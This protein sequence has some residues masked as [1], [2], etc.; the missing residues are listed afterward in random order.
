MSPS[1]PTRV[2]VCEDSKTY[3]AALTRLL[4]GGS[5]IDVVGVCE[6][7]EEAIAALRRLKPDLVTMD[8]EL[9][10]M[11]G[12]EAV[13]HIMSTTPLPIL[14]LSVHVGPRSNSAAAALAAGALD[15]LSKDSLDVTQP[16]SAAAEAFRRRVALLSRARVI[17]HP[18]GNLPRRSG[19][20]SGLRAATVI[21][22]A[23]ST[24]GP[25]ALTVVLEELP[26]SFPIPILVVQHMAAGFTEGLVH[27]LDGACSLPV[28]MARDGEPLGPGVRVAPEGA[29][30][31]L[32]GT[33]LRLDRTTVEGH[34]MPSAD[35]L[36]AS[37]AEHAGVGAVGVVLTGMGRDGAKGLAAIHEAGGIAIAQ[38]EVTSAVYGMPRAAAESAPALI[39]PPDAIAAELSHLAKAPTRA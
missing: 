5:T 12:L 21:G 31:A 38:D 27:W 32:V 24:G 39:L 26:D 33:R 29:H 2:L 4:Q 35:V 20:L 6:T 3:A 37:L 25:A 18:R 11:S 28:R 10:G 13:E 22:I 19:A 36:F 17:R 30:L 15:A 7:A 16:A 34:H 23:A 9:P 8:I 1:G 14:V